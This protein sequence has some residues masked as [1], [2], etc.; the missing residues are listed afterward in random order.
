MVHED[1]Y[2]QYSAKLGWNRKK[3]KDKEDTVQFLF[4]KGRWIFLKVFH[5]LSW[6]P[7]STD[8]FVIQHSGQLLFY[9]YKLPALRS[10]SDIMACSSMN[11]RGSLN[12]RQYLDCLGMYIWHWQQVWYLMRYMTLMPRLFNVQLR[13]SFTEKITTLVFT[14]H[15]MRGNAQQSRKRQLLRFPHNGK[16]EIFKESRVQRML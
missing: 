6:L 10:I 5:A 4:V 13:Y 1:M 12:I 3:N 11:L 14:K 7:M 9:G 8:V 2:S 15:K 16:V